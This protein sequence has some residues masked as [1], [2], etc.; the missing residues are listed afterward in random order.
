LK[1]R[2]VAELILEK[3]N[4]DLSYSDVD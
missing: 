2:N 4:P 1:L 3:S